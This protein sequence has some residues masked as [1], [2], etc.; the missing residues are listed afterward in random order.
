MGVLMGLGSVCNELWV[1]ADHKVEKF[2]GD[3]SAYKSLIVNNAK[4][5]PT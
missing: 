4:M 1:C 5:K 3:V 2:Y